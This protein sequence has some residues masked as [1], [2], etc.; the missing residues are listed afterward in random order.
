MGLNQFLSQAQTVQFESNNFLHNVE[1]FDALESLST[2]SNTILSSLEY[3]GGYAKAYHHKILN[4]SLGKLES[5]P[6]TQIS[7]ESFIIE[8][9]LIFEVHQSTSL[10]IYYYTLTFPV[11]R[12]RRFLTGEYLLRILTTCE[13]VSIKHCSAL[14]CELDSRNGIFRFLVRKFTR[15]K[16]YLG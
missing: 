11:N 9:S 7:Y 8:P 13:R 16:C 15:N 6:K 4:S 14:Q 12:M 2:D 5:V 3:E 1:D 10:M